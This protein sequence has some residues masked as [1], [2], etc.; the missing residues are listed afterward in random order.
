[1]VRCRHQTCT[2]HAHTFW[3]ALLTS[4]NALGECSLAHSKQ[5]EQTRAQCCCEQ[6]HSPRHASPRAKYM[7]ICHTSVTR[8]VQ[9][10]HRY[11][12]IRIMRHCGRAGCQGFDGIW[13]AMPGQQGALSSA[14]E[15]CALILARSA[16]QATVICRTVDPDIPQKRSLQVARLQTAQD[17]SSVRVCLC[18]LLPRPHRHRMQKS[19]FG[20]ACLAVRQPSLV[21]KQHL[22]KYVL[23]G[24]HALFQ[25]PW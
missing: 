25:S 5:D 21:G 17:A 16:V 22:N 1:M 12:P 24:P 11:G 8:G 3:A 18:N 14:G 10:M 6:R 4:S 15:R 13:L 23:R 20:Q 19:V 9:S 7:C 2:T